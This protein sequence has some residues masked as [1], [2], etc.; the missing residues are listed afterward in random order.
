MADTDR[1]IDSLA[2][3]LT[4]T[5]VQGGVPHRLFGSIDYYK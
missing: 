2:A 3:S 5:Q 4:S 1:Q